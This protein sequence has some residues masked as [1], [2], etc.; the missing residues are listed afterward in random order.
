MKNVV[1][2]WKKNVVDDA[3]KNIINDSANDVVDNEKAI[4]TEKLDEMF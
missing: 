3:I 2:D 4:A 1:F